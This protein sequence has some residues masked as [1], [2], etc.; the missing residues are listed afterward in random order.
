MINPPA[1]SG[2]ESLSS[3]GDSQGNKSIP[4]RGF[5]SFASATRKFHMSN[6][7]MIEKL[8]IIVKKY[9]ESKP[10]IKKQS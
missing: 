8:S 7:L 3:K 1:M 10:L 5:E 4:E 9:F 2:N 6:V